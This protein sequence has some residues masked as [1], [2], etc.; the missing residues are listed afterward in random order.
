[1]RLKPE[2]SCGSDMCIQLTACMPDPGV[3]SL[4]T[5]AVESAYQT[6]WSQF[7]TGTRLFVLKALPKGRKFNQDYF[8]EEVLS[9]LSRQK[10]RI[11]ERN[12]S[13]LFLSI[14]T[15]RCVMM[16]ERSV[17]NW[18]ITRS[19]EPLTQLV[20]STSAHVTF[21]R[22]VFRKKNLRNRSY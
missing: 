18:N 9:S 12:L 13:S 7:F 11:A 21:G 16:L 8:L 14:W 22:F 10:G 20:L 6:L 15:N 3:T 17:S 4:F 19:N 5:Y 2:M 1:M